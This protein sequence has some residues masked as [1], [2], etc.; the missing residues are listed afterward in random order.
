MGQAPGGF[1]SGPA[2]GL[3]KTGLAA[4]QVRQGRHGAVA[5]VDSSRPIPDGGDEGVGGNRS[6]RSSGR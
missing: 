5:A 4:H 2:N 1:W 3:A 6:E